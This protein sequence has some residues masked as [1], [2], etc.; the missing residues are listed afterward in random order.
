MLLLLLLLLLLLRNLK[1]F[2]PPV[3]LWGRAVGE[4]HIWYYRDAVLRRSFAKCFQSCRLFS[5]GFTEIHPLPS[6]DKSLS[7]AK[8][9]RDSSS[10]YQPAV[11]GHDSMPSGVALQ[12]YVTSGE[13]TTPVDYMTSSTTPRQRLSALTTTSTLLLLLRTTACGCYHTWLTLSFRMLKHA[14]TCCCHSVNLSTNNLHFISQRSIAE[15]GR[16][17]LLTQK[18]IDKASKQTNYTNTA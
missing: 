15:V 9:G 6:R 5:F 7:S 14:I 13:H 10:R 8:F 2:V 3:G 17:K 4:M 11:V 18:Q 12:R 16:L 1:L